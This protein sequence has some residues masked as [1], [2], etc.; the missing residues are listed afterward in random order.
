MLHSRR[1]FLSHGVG[2]GL[3][4][5]LALGNVTTTRAEKE[6]VVPRRYGII[7]NWDGAPHGYSDYPQTLDQFLQKTF[8]PL[9]NTQVGALFY[10]VG[11]HEAMWNSKLIPMAGDD[12]DRT[13]S[14]AGS[15][16][17]I[18]NVR[19]MLRRGENPY[20]AMGL[21]GR[22]RGIDVYASILMNDNHLHGLQVNDII[23]AR[24]EGMTQLRREHPEW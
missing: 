24:M 3:G 7:Y 5:A 6:S 9:E 22:E 4:A 8:A 10:C 20:Q 13:Y 17:H 2:A 11:E 15:M 19:A 1:E 12:Q 21:R 23:D 16:R 14:S 18:E